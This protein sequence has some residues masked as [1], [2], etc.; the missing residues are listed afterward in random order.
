MLT[1][2]SVNGE[3]RVKKKHT[4]QFEWNI[5]VK[6]P[7]RSRIPFLYKTEFN[8]AHS[9]RNGDAYVHQLYA[10]DR[11]KEKE[12]KRKL[13]ESIS[14]HAVKPLLHKS[15]LFGVRKKIRIV[16]MYSRVRKRER[17][18]SSQRGEFMCALFKHE[19]VRSFAWIYTFNPN[20]WEEQPNDFYRFVVWCFVLKMRL[21][22]EFFLV[23]RPLK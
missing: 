7:Q 10:L 15:Y 20:E 19:N 3:F 11:K 22:L 12:E 4:E 13:N 23:D 16:S 6:P 21:Y 18:N 8:I 2:T 14:F 5:S 17:S 9:S 1:V